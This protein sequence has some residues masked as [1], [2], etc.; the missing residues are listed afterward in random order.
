MGWA[1]WYGLPRSWSAIAADK[2]P[3]TKLRIWSGISESLRHAMTCATSAITRQ[4]PASCRTAAYNWRMRIPDCASFNVKWLF[5]TTTCKRPYFPLPQRTSV[6]FSE[7]GPLDALITRP[8]DMPVEPSTATYRE[9][10]HL[11]PKFPAELFVI[12]WFRV[13]SF[14]RSSDALVVALTGPLR[15]PDTTRYL[16]AHRHLPRLPP[17]PAR[18]PELP[19]RSACRTLPYWNTL[20]SLHE[21]VRTPRES[22]L[23]WPK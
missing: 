17:C 7:G 20:R 16:L 23:C 14:V 19:C 22:D 10:C 5:S 8:A 9:M 6:G 21:M 18:E 15:S 1:R 13:S 3:T 11:T 2:R 4:G 12:R